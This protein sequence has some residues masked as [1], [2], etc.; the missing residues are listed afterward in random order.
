MCVCEHIQ[1][2]PM[3]KPTV[4]EQVAQVMAFVRDSHP[5]WVTYR[6][7]MYRFEVGATKAQELCKT[8]A[9]I[10]DCYE[11]DRG[12][13]RYTG[14]PEQ[15]NSGHETLEDAF[16]DSEGDE[17]P[18]PIGEAEAHTLAKILTARPTP[19]EDRGSLKMPK[20]SKEDWTSNDQPHR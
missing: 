16:Q 9:E 14:D 5:K 6:Q 12:K 1:V 2:I 20:K 3:Q 15:F 17:E 4:K 19:P 11:Y 18:V 10:S 8:A 13:I 7:V